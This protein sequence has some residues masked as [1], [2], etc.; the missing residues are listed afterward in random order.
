[1][2]LEQ[3]PEHVVWPVVDDWPECLQVNPKFPLTGPHA[4]VAVTGEFNQSIGIELASYQPRPLS[5]L[6][7]FTHVPI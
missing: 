2:M 6:G 3:L 5:G 1:M 4:L 7:F